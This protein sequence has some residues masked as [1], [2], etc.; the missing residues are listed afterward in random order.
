MRLLL[1]PCTNSLDDFMFSL[2]RNKLTRRY[3]RV[4][5]VGVILANGVEMIPT[6][7]GFSLFFPLSTYTHTVLTN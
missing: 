5:K 4:T 1:V 6:N 2:C 7:K 3:C